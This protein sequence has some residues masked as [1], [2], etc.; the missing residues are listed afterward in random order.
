MF[1]VRFGYNPAMHRLN[2]RA[3]PFLLV[4]LAAA[5]SWGWSF[6]EHIQFA[7]IAAERLVA[8]PSTPADMKAWLSEHTPGMG[9]MEQEKAYFLHT[10]IGIVPQGFTGI[11]YYAYRPDVDA[12]GLPRDSTVAPFPDH[13]RMMHFI[14]LEVLLPKGEENQYHDD[15]S[16]KPKLADL[17]RDFHD[18]RYLQA[19]M[20]PFRVEQVYG[21]FVKAIKE[22][23]LAPDPAKMQDE[24]NAVRWAGYLAHYA[25]D[26]TQPQH[27][28]IDY[29]SATYFAEKRKAPNVHGEVEYRMIDDKDEPF[30]DLR[31]EFWP[32]FAKALQTVKDPS[33]TP[34]PWQS[35]AEVSLYSYDCLPLIGR[36]AMDAA[37]QGGTPAKPEGPASAFDTRVFFRHAGEVDGQEM[38]VMQMKARQTALA[39]IRIE[40]LWRQ[41]WKEAT[42]E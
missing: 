8:D 22:K 25:A 2:R 33:D 26:N 30:M 16:G 32:L 4:L 12:T 42:G 3:L 20:L 5:P 9:S 14:D 18:P 19:G 27:A 35:T 7:R 36:A 40:K 11:C 17:P 1:D 24:D 28:T 29:K 37:K 38:T 39:V 23:R 13:E 34:D 21:N 41:A 15:L 10:N 31:E 6:K